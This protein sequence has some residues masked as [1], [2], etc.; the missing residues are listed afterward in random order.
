MPLS[1]ALPPQRQVKAR[2]P[3]LIG[4]P[5]EIIEAMRGMRARRGMPSLQK[6]ED[7]AARRGLK[8]SHGTL[9]EILQANR[10]PTWKTLWAFLVVM[11][12]PET[13]LVAWHGAWQRAGGG[14]PRI[15]HW[16]PKPP[17]S[18]EEEQTRLRTESALEKTATR[19]SDL[20]GAAADSARLGPPENA[21]SRC[22]ELAVRPCGL[23]S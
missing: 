11:G 5:R 19:T 23:S 9:H 13:D 18:A 7:D 16:R 1:L 21:R 12:V 3:H 4:E 8:L 14:D 2:K 22:S 15:G 10:L 6:M 20:V 17:P